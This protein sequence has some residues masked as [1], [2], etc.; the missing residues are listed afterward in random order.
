MQHACIDLFTGPYWLFLLAQTEI[1]RSEK[2]IEADVKKHA[3]NG[4]VSEHAVK[5]RASRRPCRALQR[6]VLCHVVP[7]AL[8]LK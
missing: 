6:A 8:S 5:G 3:K 4:D 7:L 2:S 1:E